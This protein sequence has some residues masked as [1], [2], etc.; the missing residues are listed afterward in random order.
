MLSYHKANGEFKTLGET[1]LPS[2]PVF[3]D[4]QVRC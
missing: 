2:E 4:T 1:H 3:S